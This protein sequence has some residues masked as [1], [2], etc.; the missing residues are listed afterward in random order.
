MSEAQDLIEDAEF[1]EVNETS[2]YEAL[3]SKIQAITNCGPA[4]AA[5]VTQ[6][7]TA[8]ASEVLN[9]VL[10]DE[11]FVLSLHNNMIIAQHNA[12]SRL[13]NLTEAARRREYVVLE[14]PTD[15]SSIRVH[16]AEM[17]QSTWTLEQR[18]Q[19]GW[20]ECTLDERTQSNLLAVAGKF[21]D[22]RVGRYGYIDVIVTDPK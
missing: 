17:D 20:A 9:N 10:N 12:F 2:V 11:A 14:E 3:S 19:A 4:Q 18:T 22:S 5:E 21:F 13:R 1:E 15:T 7:V 6:L 16:Y 8:V